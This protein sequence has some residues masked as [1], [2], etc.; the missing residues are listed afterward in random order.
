[1]FGGLTTNI[2]DTGNVAS[3][4][5]TDG[6]GTFLNLSGTVGALGISSQVTIGTDGST[7]KAPGGADPALTLVATGGG[8]GLAFERVV[9]T[10]FFQIVND[11]GTDNVLMNPRVSGSNLT[12]GGTGGSG[13]IILKP[14]GTGTEFEVR[15]N[16]VGFYGSTPVAQATGSVN[17]TDNSGGTANDTIADIT[18]ANN[19]GSA[20]RVPTEDAIADLAAKVNNM[21]T[22]LRNIG[23]IAT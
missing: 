14:G 19:A 16:Q 8:Q 6:S 1:V 12:L 7:I 11:A 20:D 2:S 13:A 5:R 23:I 17:L 22:A 4:L 10:T 18:E 15:P 3:V 21:L 9:G